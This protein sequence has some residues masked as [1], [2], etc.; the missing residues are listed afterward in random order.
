MGERSDQELISACLDGDSRAYGLLIARYQ[1]PMYRTA[2]AIV[3][4]P[5]TARDIIQNG[6]I[7]TWEKLR[8]YNSDHRFYSWLYRIII[9]ESL[10]H[11]RKN[12][13]M[14]LWKE[15]DKDE[16]T[17]FSIMAE[18]EEHQ[19]LYNAVAMLDKDHRL[20]IQLRH[21]EE[22]GYQEI[23]EVLEIEEN[24]VKSRLYSARMKL[25]ELMTKGRTA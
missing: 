17:P 18:K 10:N 7:K 11:V 1:L 5:D 22:L 3:K 15:T 6:F 2:L 21:F 9:N 19:E 4:D 25:R 16:R 24:K 23:A 20:V 14:E 8:S 12:S 13:K